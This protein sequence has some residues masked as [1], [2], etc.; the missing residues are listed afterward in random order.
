MNVKEA[1]KEAVKQVS[2]KGY[3][4]IDSDPEIA[5]AYAELCQRQQDFELADERFVESAAL[6]LRAAETRLNELIR[7][8]KEQ[9]YRQRIL[10]RW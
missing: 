9:Q 6:Y 3:Q 8:K 5:A 7:Q 10:G 4:P 1:L 2:C